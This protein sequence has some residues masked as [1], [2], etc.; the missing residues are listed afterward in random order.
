MGVAIG[1]WAHYNGW[2]GIH[3]MVP[4]TSDTWKQRVGL[5]SIDSIPDVTMSPTSYTVAPPTSLRCVQK[6]HSILLD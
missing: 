1:G 4:N 5:R 3:G 2:N 6:A